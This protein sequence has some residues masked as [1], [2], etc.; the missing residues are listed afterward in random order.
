M[1]QRP[2]IAKGLGFGISAYL[3]WGSFPLV[4]L[5]LAFANPFEI[6]VWRVIFGL[7]FALI[8]MAVSRAFKPYFA[9]LKRPK[10]LGWLAV[11]A[12]TIFINWQV[13]VV[14]VVNGQVLEAS[15]GYFINPLITV[16]IAVLFLS[17]KLNR[18]QLIAMLLG[19]VAV[20][21][22]AFGYGR[23]PWIAL[24]LATTFGLY[25]LAKNRMGA[26]VGALTSFAV[27]TTLLL[28]IA[29]VQLVILAGFTQV[30]FGHAGW[31]QSLGLAG[32]GAL[33]AI[34]LILFG[35]SAKRVPL[36][37]LGFMQ[38]LTPILQFM[39]GLLILG[40]E[41]TPLRWFG[42]L[43]VWLAS[44]ILTVDA[45]RSARNRSRTATPPAI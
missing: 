32:Y 16:A 8:L 43:T 2:E 14:A 10:Q 29:I 31:W 12:I 1:P 7:L 15:L 45:Y 19:L 25:G 41:M 34:P 26:K 44:T 22:L 5:A 30:Q 42:F 37:Y 17:E 27:E 21:V 35:A 39:I 9:M 40:E 38:F 11:A 4:I 3:I 20:V 28:P 23:P 36:S 33:T 6:V 24:T 18:A 13:Y